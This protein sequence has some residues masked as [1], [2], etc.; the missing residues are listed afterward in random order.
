VLLPFL[1]WDF[2]SFWQDVYQYPAGSLPTSYPITGYGFGLFLYI[3]G[4][5][6][7]SRD[8]YP[9]IIWQAVICWPVLLLLLKLQKQHNSVNYMFLAYTIFLALFWFFSRFF[10]DNYIVFLGQLLLIVYF[11]NTPVEEGQSSL[12]KLGDKKEI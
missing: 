12:L 6:K 7:S 9:F 1:C 10:N 8:Y 4:F 3:F 2:R 5:I 11:I